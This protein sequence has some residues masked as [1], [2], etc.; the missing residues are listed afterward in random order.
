MS[1]CHPDFINSISLQNSKYQEV[2]PDHFAEQIGIYK[3]VYQNI[4]SI[5]CPALVTK[6][7][8]LSG[9]KEIVQFC[10]P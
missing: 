1:N 4:L 3:C 2:S 9:L 7:L 6:C 5:D 10:D 8:V